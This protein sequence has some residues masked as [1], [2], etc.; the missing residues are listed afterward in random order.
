[1]AYDPND[2]KDKKIVDDA[3][4][5]ALADAKVEHDAEIA[6]L[7]T[8]NKELLGKLA[9]AKTGE[10]D[11]DEVSRLEAQIE[12]L[13]GK[14]KEA[15]KVSKKLEKDLSTAQE[16]A[17]K[18]GDFSRKL[19]IDNGLSEQ[20]TANGV[21]AEFLPAVKAM[22]SGKVT[23]KTEGDNRTAVVGDKSLGDFVKEWS[24]GDEGKHYV[25]AANNGGGGA[26]GGGK[27]P[28]GK[29]MTRA[30]YDAL[31]PGEASAFFASG[32]TLTE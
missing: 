2:P 9:K 11:P 1:M 23:I 14:L 6:G 3:V 29:T 10:G 24:Q 12:E 17:T 28:G 27:A 30:Q 20:L 19:L 5:E 31:P 13:Q 15:D 16:N 7:K 21:K 26:P 4:A 25:A 22:L 18:E 8:K 32:G